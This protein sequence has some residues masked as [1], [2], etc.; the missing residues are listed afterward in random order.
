M[1]TAIILAGGIGQRFGNKVPKQFTTINGKTIVEITVNKFREIKECSEI[2]ICCQEDYIDNM[3]IDYS[4]CILVTG[5]R[6][7]HES[8]II[9]V[10]AIQSSNEYVMIH[11]AVRPLV[12]NAII[13]RLLNK[14]KE[15]DAVVPIIKIYDSILKI[16][17]TIENADRDDYCGIHTPEAF[18]TAVIREVIKESEKINSK[19]N[20]EYSRAI[21]LGYK[22]TTVES[23]D[24]NI[25]LTTKHD[26]SVIESRLA[27]AVS[28]LNV[29]G[30]LQ[31]KRALILGGSSGIGYAIGEQLKEKGC[32]VDTYG[33][34][35]HLE[36]GLQLKPKKYNIII[37]S[38]GTFS[39]NGQTIIKPFSQTKYE[40]YR[41]CMDLM[42]TSAYNVAK[43][44]L[45]CIEDGHLIFIGSSSYNKGR[46]QFSIYSPPK[47]A[48]NC[49]VE[50]I[51]DE[52]M[53]NGIRVNCIN[54]SRTDTKMRRY[55]NDEASIVLLKPSEVAKVVVQYCLSNVHGE[56]R[57]IR[58]S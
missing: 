10:N 9:G 16:G 56:L 48:L 31:N 46:D 47:A 41:Y 43:Y 51:A 44:A 30:S 33:S 29:E 49:F 35:L 14:L 42:M 7:R 4:D 18:K 39:Y 53:E 50:A 27:S 5:G 17:E 3:R 36:N 20:T 23:E 52:F 15:S 40:E 58:V 21:D 32:E 57:S 26:L 55:V 13:N 54:P 6:S 25:K 24:C 2:I 34:E 38:V 28:N 8:C 45:E 19:S 11:D 12:T 22:C 1:F 37:H